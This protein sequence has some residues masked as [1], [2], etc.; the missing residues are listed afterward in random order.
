MKPIAYPYQPV[1]ERGTLGCFLLALLMHVFLGVLLYYGVHWQSSTPVGLQA[2]LWDATPATTAQPPEPAALP[3]PAPAP[4]VQPKEEEADIALQQQKRREAAAARQE[5]Q[6]Q[7]RQQAREQADQRARLAREEAD[8]RA[9]Q[10]TAAN[11]QR[12][13]ELERLQA[14]A[15]GTVASQGVGNRAGNTAG[16][17]GTASSGYPDRVRRRVKPNIIFTEEVSGNP[18]AVVAVQL[19]PDGSLL[20]ARLTKSSGNSAWDSAVL[21]AVERSDPLPRDENGI[22][23]GSVTLT[24]KP[25]D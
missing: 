15:G 8:A 6:E 19:A 5:A 16:A 24:F 12:R 18:A 14:Q 22:A 9:R 20:S 1:P 25:K 3:H 21:R 11:A 4:T 17:G 13:S 23:P 10:A 7:A 2:E